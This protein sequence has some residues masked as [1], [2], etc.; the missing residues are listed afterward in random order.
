MSENARE[1]TWTV[2]EILQWTTS[3]F[4]DHGIESARLDAEVLLAHALG[5][6]RLDLYL[7]YEKPLLPDE[8]AA[9]RE[10]VKQRAHERI[11]VSLLL[12]CREFWSLEFKV[13]RD[14][15]TPRPETE[16]LVSEAIDFLTD[17]KRA[18]NVIDIGT[19]SGAIALAIASERP[20]AQ[21]VATDV[22]APALKVA[23]E[24]ADQLQLKGRVRFEQ[25][26]LFDAVPG[27]RFDLVVSNPPYIAGAERKALARELTHE[28]ELALFGGDDGYAVLRPLIEGLGS[29]LNDGGLFLVE[30]DPRQAE[31]VARLCEEAGLSGV[32][33]L[34]DLAG[35][36]RAVRASQ[37]GTGGGSFEEEQK[38]ESSR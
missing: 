27:E 32:R 7:N 8:R 13:T 10:F 2:L 9:F 3:H 11:P 38:L 35:N 5:M 1:R 17:E 28:P 30:L 15:L 34:H 12:G 19:G 36:A 18:Y 33:V 20:H 6:S 29:V 24:N 22:S 26:S 25:G 4:R 21:V 14:V 16:L 37:A 31:T 23:Q